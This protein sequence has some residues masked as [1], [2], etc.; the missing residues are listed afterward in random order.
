MK[1]IFDKFVGQRIGINVETLS[2]YSGAK[3][4]EATHNFLSVHSDDKKTHHIPYS[5]IL[6]VSEDERGLEGN[7]KLFV[8]NEKF[9]LVVK[10]GHITI[11][12]IG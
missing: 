5:N 3:L 6:A 9:K 7:K 8:E 2:K 12:S 1:E 11:H 4:L 10:I